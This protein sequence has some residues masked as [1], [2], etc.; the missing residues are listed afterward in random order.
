M[1]VKSEIR[2]FIVENFLYGQD[3][4][5]LGDDVSFM[6]SGIIDSTGVLELVSFVQNKYKIRVSD[7][8]LIPTN[9]DS[10][11]LLVSFIEKKSASEN[12]A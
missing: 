5:T 9:F 2:H 11:K 4:N 10:L 6:E 1:Q 8:E 3:D 7:E 12:R